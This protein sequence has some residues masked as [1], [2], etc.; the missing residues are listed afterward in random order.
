MITDREA[1]TVKLRTELREGLGSHK[2]NFGARGW[3]YR[4]LSGNTAEEFGIEQVGSN[5]LASAQRYKPSSYDT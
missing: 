2:A 4:Q 3:L 5:T 1:S